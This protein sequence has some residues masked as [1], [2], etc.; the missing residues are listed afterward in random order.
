MGTGRQEIPDKGKG[1]AKFPPA[2]CI[3]WQGKFRPL[4][5]AAPRNQSRPTGFLAANQ[6]VQT[7]AALLLGPWGK[8]EH[9]LV[10]RE[11]TL[12]HRLSA[13]PWWPGGVTAAPLHRGTH[14]SHTVDCPNSGGV[15][16]VPEAT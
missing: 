7:E 14:T 16:Q 15:E 11:E 4:L 13:A 3:S 2:L 10:S 5:S 6:E 9:P 8:G 12:A 1:T